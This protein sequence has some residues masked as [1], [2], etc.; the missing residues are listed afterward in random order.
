MFVYA[1]ITNTVALLST[2]NMAFQPSVTVQGNT[3]EVREEA[4]N[5]PFAFAVDPRRQPTSLRE[6]IDAISRALP[7]SHLELIAAYMGYG[8]IAR[9]EGRFKRPA[10][11]TAALYAPELVHSAWRSWGFLDGNDPLRAR[12]KCVGE[13]ALPKWVILQIGITYIDERAKEGDRTRARQLAGYRQAALAA[14]RLFEICD[15]QAASASTS[16]P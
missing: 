12:T 15:E 4:R 10:D 5:L 9:F 16:A 1:S 8:D 3:I 11:F 13:S 6:A 14:R 7:A 2:A